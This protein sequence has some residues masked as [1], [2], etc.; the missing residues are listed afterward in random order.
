MTWTILVLVL[1]IALY[2]FVKPLFGLIS[3]EKKP[4]PA[5]KIAK[6]LVKVFAIIIIAGATAR[7]YMPYYLTDV[8]PAILQEMAQNM[9]NAGRKSSDKE[10]KSYVKKHMDEMVANAPVLGNPEASKTI[11]VF[12]AYSCGYCRRV[13]SELVNVIADR[14]DVRVVMKQFSIHGAMSDAP[15]KA[16]IAAKLQG[17]DKAVA[18]DMKLMEKEYYSQEDTKDQAKVGDK[19]HANIMKIAKEV[20][21]DT[22]QLEADMKGAVVA[23]ELAQVRDLAQKFNI[24]G[25]PFLIIE[26]KA[27]PG[28]IPADQIREALK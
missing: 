8:N 21:L 15:A 17:N 18:L 5:M 7:L 27:F 23:K 4:V 19:I 26:G 2:V 24:S 1:G 13:H 28:A 11:F 10:I 3:N 16:V 22:K 14:D 25:T 12:S 6:K 20:G 9:Q